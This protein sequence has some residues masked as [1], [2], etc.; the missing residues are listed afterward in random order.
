MAD[1]DNIVHKAEFL[2]EIRAIAQT[3]LAYT[4]NPSDRERYEKLLALVVTEYS[5]LSGLTSEEVVER[6]RNELGYVTP[7]LAVDAAIFS[8]PGLLRESGMDP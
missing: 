2:E 4:E 3:G 7:K 8:D 5:K 1:V 6:F